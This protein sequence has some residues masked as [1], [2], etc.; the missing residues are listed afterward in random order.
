VGRIIAEF[1]IHREFVKDGKYNVKRNNIIAGIT[2]S[3]IQ[4]IES[5]EKI[6]GKLK[7]VGKAEKSHDYHGTVNISKVQITLPYYKS[8]NEPLELKREFIPFLNRLIE[9]VRFKT[10]A[11][12]IT[13]LTEHDI[14]YFDII[15]KVDDT[16]RATGG[17]SLV[18]DALVFPIRTTD[19]ENVKEEI[20]NLL[21]NEIQIPRVESLLL[22]SYNYFATSQFNLAVIIANTALEIFIE[23]HLKL[24][25]SKKYS[26]KQF[27]SKLSL[28]L[29]G[30]NLHHKV[31]RNFFNNRKHNELIN[32]NT[33]YQNFDYARK[34]RAKAVHNDIEL[35]RDESMNTIKYILGFI[36]HLQKDIDEVSKGY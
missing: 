24:I 20:S 17:F 11:Y 28:A 32:S 3:R 19:Q 8:F 2:V 31:A 9:V 27:Q 18:P 7:S 10:N 21:E 22:D 1:T 14:E 5:M 35:E 4:N 33:L 26:G 13:P 6:M 36:E 23:Q 25:L 15:E 30:K 34:S 29:D 12:W 16:G